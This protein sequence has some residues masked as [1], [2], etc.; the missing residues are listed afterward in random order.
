MSYNRDFRLFSLAFSGKHACIIV[1]VVL[2]LLLLAVTY[3]NSF[4][5][6]WVFDDAP[7]ILDNPNIRVEDLSTDSLKRSLYDQNGRLNRPLAYLTFGLNYYF[8]G[9]NV[10][11]YHLVNLA[12]HFLTAVFL[13]LFIL[14]TLNLPLLKDRYSS[15]TYS[16]ALLAA[17]FWAVNPVQV[18]AVTYIVQRMASMAGLFYIAAMY[19]YLSGRTARTHGRRIIFIS[20]A[21][22]SSMLAFT[23]KQNAAMLPVST[24]LYDLFLIQGITRAS[25]KKTCTSRAHE[26]H[27]GIAC[28]WLLLPSPGLPGP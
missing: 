4:K 22:V 12:V 7:N 15:H 28:R 1:P 14:K 11:G 21:A 24:F 2:L 8:G 19:L 5:G 18:T 17:V 6:D 23:S 3:S 9:T 26:G 13:F 16:I 20:G 27:E 10:F 25:P